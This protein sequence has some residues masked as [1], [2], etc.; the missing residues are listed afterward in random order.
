[1]SIPEYKIDGDD[2]NSFIEKNIVEL[3]KL[4]IDNLKY[5]YQNNIDEK[6]AF[7]LKHDDTIGVSK[8]IFKVKLSSYNK[9]IDKVIKSFEAYDMFE[10]CIDCVDL[11]KKIEEKINI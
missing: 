10:E 11:K 9:I 2:Y 5:C 1:M 7:I 8:Y 3:S 6:D 4:M